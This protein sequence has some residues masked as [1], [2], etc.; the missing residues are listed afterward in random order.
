MALCDINDLY[1]AKFLTTKLVGISDGRPPRTVTGAA[2]GFLVSDEEHR[3]F[4][5]SNRHVL[6]P[7][8]PT[9]WQGGTAPKT[10]LESVIVNGHCLD[11]NGLPIAQVHK[12][13]RPVVTCHSNPRVDIAV[14][15]C[16]K[17]KHV[18]GE[19]DSCL[20]VPSRE[21]ATETDF[22]TFLPGE[23]LHIPGYPSDYADRLQFPIVRTGHLASDPRRGFSP[24]FPQGDE[25]LA[26]DGFITPGA[27][28]S[29]VVLGGCETRR[30]VG[31]A[32][33]FVPKISDMKAQKTKDEMDHRGMS[34]FVR[35]CAVLEV[36]RDAGA[37]LPTDHCVGIAS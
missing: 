24:V 6:R 29:P 15:S 26:I 19:A 34:L 35:S 36:L 16:E 8:L 11:E 12:L 10:S 22:A 25:L 20:S 1:L 32:R 37:V 5:V 17:L 31:V 28:G 3:Q 13:N 21:F 7:S 27:S 30:F 23:V 14:A 9:E 18:S 33:S 4:L 2:T